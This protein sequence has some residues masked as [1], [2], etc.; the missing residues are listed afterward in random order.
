MIQSVSVGPIGENVYIV[1]N[2]GTPVVVVDPGAEAERL[3]PLITT[4]FA[5]TKAL[6]VL[7]VCTHGHLDHVAAIPGILA[8]LGRQGIPVRLLAPEADRA[9]FG[10]AAEATNRRVFSGIHAME[11]FDRYWRPIPEADIYYTDGYTI[12]GTGI[13]AI[14]TPGHTAG[15]SCL[16]AEG[17]TDLLSGDTLFRDG[18]GRTDNFDSDEA[19][20]VSS[21]RDKLCILPDSVRVWPGHGGQTNIGREKRWYA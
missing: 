6:E 16:L 19:V 13:T 11:F 21:I 10:D 17:G 7:L 14:H 15:S 2:P 20:I 5:R 9:Y 3:L 18:R 12:P 4:S 1:E 8:G